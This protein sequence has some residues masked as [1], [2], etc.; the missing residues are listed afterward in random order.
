MDS[1]VYQR[2]PNTAAWLKGTHFADVEIP[3][4]NELF[5][6]VAAAACG[7]KSPLLQRR[8]DLK[9]QTAAKNTPAAP[10]VHINFPPEFANFLRPAVAPAPAAPDAFILP[11]NTANMLIPH[12]RIPGLDLSIEDF[13]SLYDLYTDICKRFKEHKFKRSNAFKFV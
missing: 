7:A 9:E 11:L 8:L 4:N 12:P 2:A 5:D 10:Q 1:Q 3:P 13:C 6:R